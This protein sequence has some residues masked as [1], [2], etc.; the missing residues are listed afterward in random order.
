MPNILDQ[1]FIPSIADNRRWTVSDAKDKKPMDMRRLLFGDTKPCGAKYQD[2]RSLCSLSEIA[3]R[4]NILLDRPVYSHLSLPLTYYCKAVEAKFCIL[5]IEKTCPDDVRQRLLKMPYLYGERSSSG[6]GIHLLFPLP[7]HYLDYSAAMQKPTLKE[8]H[9]WYEILL[10]H[11]SIF[12]VNMLDPPSNPNGAESFDELF[13]ELAAQAKEVHAVA[14]DLAKSGPNV[15][16]PIKD[17]LI[18]NLVTYG[19][20]YKKTP[21]DFHND[22][23]TYEFGVIGYLY[24]RLKYLT[25]NQKDKYTANDKIWL[26]YEAVKQTLPHRSKHDEIR[27]GLPYLLSET[28]TCVA[29]NEQAEIDKQA[30][31]KGGGKA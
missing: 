26:L 20:T 14:V 10:N 12:T 31:T 4:A 28:K 16:E 6:K 11:Y 15:A 22:M 29:R 21:A 9:R 1:P 17:A 24:A 19:K 13:Y 5:D 25:R 23:S 27:N 18:R 8:E 3:Q 30:E 2:E 7:K